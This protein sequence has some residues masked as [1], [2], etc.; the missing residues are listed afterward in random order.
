[1]QQVGTLS[2]RV[3]EEQHGEAQKACYAK[4]AAVR[5]GDR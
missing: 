4:G 1:M 3:L 5:V 2:S